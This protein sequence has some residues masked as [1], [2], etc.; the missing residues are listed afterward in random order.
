M[1][2]LFIGNSSKGWYTNAKDMKNMFDKTLYFSYPSYSDRNKIWKKEVYKKLGNDI[3]LNF[4][5]LA[6]MSQNFSAE[7]IIKTINYTLTPQRI[8]KSRFDPVLTNE[9][10]SYLSKN[11]FLFKEEFIANRD[12]LFKS[13]RIGRYT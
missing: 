4:D 12:F 11:N 13:V 10:I 2:I 7:S 9:F 3:E 8:D 6:Q 1:R 5:V